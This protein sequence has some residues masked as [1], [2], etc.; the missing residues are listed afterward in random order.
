MVCRENPLR[1]AFMGAVK[2]LSVIN[3]DGYFHDA[4]VQ[5]SI[6]E[7][8]HELEAMTPISTEQ[9]IAFAEQLR[10]QLEANPD[11]TDNDKYR[12]FSGDRGQTGII[13]RIDDEIRALKTGKDRKGR[14]IKGT[15]KENN[16]RFLAS[17]MNMGSMLERRQPAKAA[18]LEMN[19]RHRGISMAEA[20]AEWN[21]LMN[22]KGDFSQISLSDTFREDL[23]SGRK[24]DGST[25]TRPVTLRDSLAMAGMSA[26][27][28]ADLGQ[29]GRARNAMA[30]MEQRR[31]KAVKALPSRP[32]L[33]VPGVVSRQYLDASKKD[34]Y[35]KCGQCGQFG[36]DDNECPNPDLASERRDLSNQRDTLD[37][38][39]EAVKWR[40]MLD[41]DDDAIM[42][43][44]DR[45]YPQREF[46]SA[47]QFREM[48]A[49]RIDTLTPD[50]E[51]TE[52]EIA[53]RSKQ[54][55]DAEA[56]LRRR[57]DERGGSV[58]AFRSVRYSPQTGL[59]EV[60][61]QDYTRKNGHVTPG[62]PFYRRISPQQWA[63]LTDGTDSIGAR[64]NSLG[65]ARNPDEQNRFESA[66]DMRA[67]A[68]L[69]RCPTCGRF[70]S[71]NAGHRCAVKGGPSEEFT[72]RNALQQRAYRR[73]V[74]EGG[75]KVPPPP[76]NIRTGQP[77]DHHVI[78][79]RETDGAIVRG[80]LMTA[81]RGS[82]DADLATDATVAHPTVH[83]QFPGAT[84]TGSVQ[85][86]SS[87]GQRFLSVADDDRNVT[88]K[89]TCPQYRK[90]YRCPHVESA[91]KACAD[92]FRAGPARG[93]TA[94]SSYEQLDGFSMD[95]PL[96]T[97]SRVDFATITAR[98]AEHNDTFTT[99]V[100]ARSYA[101]TFATSPV[102]MPPRN[103]DGEEI[104]E[105][106]VWA[107]TD[108]D[109][110]TSAEDGKKRMDV[111][112]VDLQN[113]GDVVHRLRKVLSGRKGRQSWSVRTDQ[114]GGI[115]V[116]IQRSARNTPAAE[117]QRATLRSLLNIPANND[118]RNGFYIPPTGSARHEALDRAYGDPPRIQQS[119]MVFTPDAEAL[120]NARDHRAQ[121]RN[122]A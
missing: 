85:V 23:G 32:T 27:E 119:R 11:L 116:D 64:L 67:A 44:L 111:N 47:A 96:G 99:S 122:L 33:D 109:D 98:R 101:G 71:L 52:L 110:D 25:D 43:N 84:V 104:A 2:K 91:A 88:L 57:R 77:V 15:P 79:A 58:S 42:T 61:P 50:G 39:K 49:S 21:K 66:A 69:Q 102:A 31:L 16:A 115:I 45:Y 13:T 19:A 108:S 36:H 26:R 3:G 53:R 73:A 8:G 92:K 90:N 59:L 10:A 12:P 7:F 37:K 75:G 81:T 100:N 5:S 97:H 20:T 9:Q 103:S 86:W 4:E 46:A 22:T 62:K 30:V 72:A 1:S 35:V 48:V 82:I 113:T 114:F 112:K 78:G 56:D 121:T 6:H 63:E 117:S 41:A 24:T 17:V 18:F 76:R 55:D 14:P 54:L 80:D 74:V 29:S 83:A 94:N 95:A 38:A 51:L 105:P 34:S 68:T 40:R 93:R 106:T 89:C 70:A 65:L 28:Q 120:Q 87:D 60:T 118:L 107:R